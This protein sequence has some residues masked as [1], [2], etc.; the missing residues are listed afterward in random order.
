[1]GGQMKT[2]V[3]SRSLQD[4][5][6]VRCPCPLTH[7]ASRRSPD[8]EH[9]SLGRSQWTHAYAWILVHSRMSCV[10]N[11]FQPSRDPRVLVGGA[12]LPG[13]EVPASTRITAGLERVGNKVHP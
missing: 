7:V 5:S 11:T 9:P 8:R 3:R 10:P 12:L 6:K 13:A 2:A 4:L 1:M